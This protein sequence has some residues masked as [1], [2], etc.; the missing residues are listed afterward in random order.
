MSPNIE[1]VDDEIDAGENNEMSTNEPPAKMRKSSYSPNEFGAS[2]SCLESNEQK[3]KKN[4]IKTILGRS[5]GIAQEPRE[6]VRAYSHLNDYARSNTA[7]DTSESCELCVFIFREKTCSMCV[8]VSARYAQSSKFTIQRQ[9][10]AYSSVRR[11]HRPSSSKATIAGNSESGRPIHQ[12]GA[13]KKPIPICAAQVLE[14]RMGANH[15]DDES[16]SPSDSGN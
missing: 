11:V 6:K 12:S 9:P 10:N 13:K 16:D 14:E 3:R 15:Y 5:V 7:S 2:L 1:G 8:N 4:Q